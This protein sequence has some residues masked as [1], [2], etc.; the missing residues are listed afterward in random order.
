M[1]E[2]ETSRPGFLARAMIGAI[3]LYQRFLSPWLGRHCRFHPSCSKYGVLA[4]E[5]YGAIGGMARTAYRILRCNP[6]CRGGVD[7]P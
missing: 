4:I 5:K 6:F 3:R 2:P 7:F 1:N